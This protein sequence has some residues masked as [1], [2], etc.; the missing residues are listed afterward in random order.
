MLDQTRA[1]GQIALKEGVSPDMVHNVI[2]WGNHSK[3]MFPNAS[4]AFISTPGSQEKRTPACVSD[5]KWLRETFIPTVQNRGA[6]VIAA[7]GSSSAL[8]AANA[9]VRHMRTWYEGTAE[10]KNVL[11]DES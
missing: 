4:R 10:V 2:I 3:T 9:V 7:R 5:E 8:S 1:E 6:A 11:D